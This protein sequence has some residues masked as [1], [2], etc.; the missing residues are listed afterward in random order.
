MNKPSCTRTLP[1]CSPRFI[2]YRARLSGGR[3]VLV[4]SEPRR[5]AGGEVVT[6]AWE[7]DDASQRLP[8]GSIH[9]AHRA[10]FQWEEPRCNLRE[11]RD[12]AACAAREDD[13]TEVRVL[14]TYAT[15]ALAMKAAIANGG[16]EVRNLHTGEVWEI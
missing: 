15:H 11:Q 5:I 16:R 6:V 9:P 13:E 12:F 2:P 4:L 8:D 1:A 3:V 7:D 10:G 14:N